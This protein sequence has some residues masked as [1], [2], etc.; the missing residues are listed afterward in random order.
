M[1]WEYASLALGGWTPPDT[2]QAPYGNSV[3]LSVCH[4]RS[5]R[6]VYVGPGKML[7]VGLSPGQ[8]SQVKLNHCKY[9]IIVITYGTVNKM[10]T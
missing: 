9:I 5:R 7:K 4:T 2:V 6:E 8:L 3:C 10:V 1:K